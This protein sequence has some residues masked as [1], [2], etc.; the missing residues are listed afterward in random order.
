M[1]WHSEEKET[2][3]ITLITKSNLRLGVL[4]E[5]MKGIF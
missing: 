4:P 1:P 2:G 5:L 3:V